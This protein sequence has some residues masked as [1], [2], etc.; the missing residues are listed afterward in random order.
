MAAYDD[1]KTNCLAAIT[2]AKAFLADRDVQANLQATFAALITIRD[3]MN[4]WIRAEIALQALN[5]ATDQGISTGIDQARIQDLRQDA[6]RLQDL[7][8]EIKDLVV[9]IAGKAEAP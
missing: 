7:G 3:R 1:A 9:L 5:A 4:E 8:T 6:K 2:S